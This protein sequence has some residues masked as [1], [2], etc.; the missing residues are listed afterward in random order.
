MKDVIKTG[1][2]KPYPQKALNNTLG[3]TSKDIASVIGVTHRHLLQDLRQRQY[4]KRLEDAGFL[5]AEISINS[6]GRGRK[7]KMF[8]LDSDA[9]KAVVAQSRTDSGVGYLRYLI[10]CERLWENDV[11][12]LLREVEDLRRKVQALERPRQIRSNP[13]HWQIVIGYRELKTL[14]GEE[15]K[16]V[17]RREALLADMTVEERRQWEAAHNSKTAAGLSKKVQKLLD[18]EID[19]KRVVS[20]VRKEK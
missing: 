13:K 14:F 17:V 7:G 1:F 3:L 16:E 6:K 20:L 15:V 18:R 5:L 2:V 10:E 9:S 11:P 4:V 8:V 12:R 19:P